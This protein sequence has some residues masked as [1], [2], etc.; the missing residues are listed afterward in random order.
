[1][2]ITL[3]QASGMAMDQFFQDYAPRDSFFDEIDFRAHFAAIYSNMLD[4]E[5]QQIRKENKA[6]DGFSA[7]EMSSQW[8]VRE[9]LQVQKKSDGRC[10][11]KLASNLFS[12]NFDAF[13][14]AL[15]KIRSAATADCDKRCTIIHIS[16][17]ESKFLDVSPAASVV[18][19][20]VAA[21]N[22]IELSGEACS[23]EVQYVPAVDPTNP[24]CIISA[25]IADRVITATL[26]RFFASRN[27]TVVDETNDG[28]KNNVIDQQ[29]NPINKKIQNT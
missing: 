29:T 28:N 24:G 14:Y 11:A 22:E 21:C 23:L 5:F 16:A 4:A 8:L 18:Y 6:L 15:D 20:W 19:A 7:V 25:A 2:Q 17:D 27:G 13:N 10:Y 26:Q 3:K 9:T 1:M 12:F